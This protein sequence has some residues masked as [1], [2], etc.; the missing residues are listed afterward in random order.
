MKK[1]SINLSL[2]VIMIREGNRFIAYSP[3]LDLSTSGK[4]HKEASKRFKEIANIFFEEIVKQGTLEDVLRDLGWK[5]T[6]KKW[7]PPMVISQ[8]FQEVKV[9]A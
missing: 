3:A 7:N 4:T 6:R 5:K 1:S 8:E 2:S 9:Y